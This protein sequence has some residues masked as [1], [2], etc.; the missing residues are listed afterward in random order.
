MTGT[1]FIMERRG[2]RKVKRHRVFGTIELKH[3][4]R[5]DNNLVIALDIKTQPSDTFLSH[6]NAE[7]NSAV[8]RCPDKNQ[9]VFHGQV[10]SVLEN[11]VHTTYR[12]P[13]EECRKLGVNL[14]SHETRR[15]KRRS[16][17]VRASTHKLQ[18]PSQSIR[19]ADELYRH[20]S[21]LHLAPCGQYRY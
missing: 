5:P 12:P 18:A 3:V 10:D 7:W 8:L 2:L 1:D 11:A 9:C 14:L 16:T 19:P 15:I 20:R 17:E 6:M 21:A 13:G 4:R